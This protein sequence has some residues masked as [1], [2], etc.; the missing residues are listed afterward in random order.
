MFESISFDRPQT[1]GARIKV[2]GVGGCGGNAV[3][4]LIG[5]DLPHIHFLAANTDQQALEANLAGVKLQIGAGLTNGLGAGGDPEVGHRAALEDIDALRQHFLDADMV[6]ITA[7][8]GGGTGTGA[9]PVVAQT[10]RDA[11][12]LTVAVVTK[13]FSFEGRQRIRQAEEG[14]RELAQAVDTLIVIPNDRIFQ[15]AN[16]RMPIKEAFRMVDSVVV[17]AVRGISDMIAIPGLINVDFAD[18]KAI[19]K[20]KGMALMGTGRGAGEERAIIAAKQAISSPLLEDARIEG[21][22]GLLV[23]ISGSSDMSIADLNDAMM[24]IQ[25]ATGADTNTIFGTTVDESLGEEIKVTVVATG[26]DR[27]AVVRAQDHQQTRLY[28]SQRAATERPALQVVP[29]PPLQRAH[30]DEAPVYAVAMAAHERAAM[31]QHAQSAATLAVHTATTRPLPTPSPQPAMEAPPLPRHEHELDEPAFMRKNTPGYGLPAVGSLL[32]T[33]REPVV[34]NPFTN[35][36][37]EVDRPA[38]RRK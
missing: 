29:P 19:M 25:D 9:A 1:A 37:D 23:T 12:A 32:G 10:A 13:P 7:G 14:L 15:I 30:S 34:H 8:M 6:F 16:P 36:I 38:F 5:S 31:A 20:G 2:V 27:A 22:T 24:L 18:V 4:N 3:N 26:F 21:A 17:E 35:N 11:G 33:K 28:G